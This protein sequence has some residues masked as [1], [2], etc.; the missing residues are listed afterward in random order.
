MIEP[1][2]LLFEDFRNYDKKYRSQLVCIKLMEKKHKRWLADG[3][4]YWRYNM[5]HGYSDMLRYKVQHIDDHHEEIKNGI[6]SK[7]DLYANEVIRKKYYLLKSQVFMGFKNEW[8]RTKQNNKKIIPMLQK[9]DHHRLF[10]A[11]RNWKW[12]MFYKKTKRSY[13]PY[14]KKLYERGLKKD[15]FDVLKIHR[16]EIYNLFDLT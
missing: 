7:A 3:F 12:L 15:V 5:R 6:F 1:Y 10:N 2:Q 8:I 14:K 16:Q 4:S 13:L 11:M 9:I